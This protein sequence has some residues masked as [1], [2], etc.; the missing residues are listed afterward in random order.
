MRHGWEVTIFVYA[1]RA[2]LDG[3]RFSISP[4]RVIISAGNERREIPLEY[5]VKVVDRVSGEQIY[6]V[7]YDA[8]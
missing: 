3:I 7:N 5:I 6:L 2:I 1:H 4:S 8:D